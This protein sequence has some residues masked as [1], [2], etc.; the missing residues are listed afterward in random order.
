MTHGSGLDCDDNEDASPGGEG[1]MQMQTAK[2]DWW[3][4][5]LDLKII[6]RTG[7]VMFGREGF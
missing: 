6:L 1:N 5:M 4:Y 7:L 2:P 3:K